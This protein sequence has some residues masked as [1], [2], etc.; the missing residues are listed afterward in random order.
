MKGRRTDPRVLRRRNWGRWGADDERGAL[1]LITPNRILKASGLVRQ[2]VAVSLGR[3][4]APDM[5]TPPQRLAPAHFMTS[6]GGDFPSRDGRPYRIQFGDDVVLMST[7][8]GS[9]VD[10][11]SHLWYDGELYNGFPQ[12]VVR[13]QGGA[14]RCGVDKL[15]PIVARGVLADIAG[16]Q[17]VRSLPDDYRIT[18]EVLESCLEREGTE[19][20]AGDVLLIRTGWWDERAAAGDFTREPGV[21]VDGAAW[22]VEREIAAVGA[23]NFAFEALPAGNGSM[24]PVHELLLCDCGVPILEGLALDQLAAA[25]VSAFLFVVAP[26][27][28]EGATASPVNP[29]AIL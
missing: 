18:G 26:L 22:L 29:V 7:H 1:N 13:S 20:T 10:A 27:A 12:E 15:G 9:H 6:D 24:F 21:D 5:P 3:P 11:L 14:R 8:T 2:G 19:L 23:D 28:F 16:C 4:L 17:D 25:R